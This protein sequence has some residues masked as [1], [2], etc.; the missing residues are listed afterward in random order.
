M[1][2]VDKLKN[3]LSLVE[4]RGNTLIFTCPVCGGSNLKLNDSVTSEKYGAY[5]C[6]DNSCSPRD[7][8]E[9]LGLRLENNIFQESTFGPSNIFTTSFTLEREPKSFDLSVSN[10]CQVKEN[11]Q[12]P[13][14]LNIKPVQRVCYYYSP[15]HRLVRLNGRKKILIL[16]YWSDSGWVAGVGQNTWPLYLTGC[17]LNSGDTLAMVEGEKTAEKVKATGLACATIC[18]AFF[19]TNN[20]YI[21]FLNLK[22]SSNIRNIVYIP[23][24]DVPG[25]K[26][27]QEVSRACEY[28]GFSY[29]QKDIK[30]LN[31]NKTPGFDLADVSNLDIIRNFIV[32]DI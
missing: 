6:W 20:I 24:D 11:Y 31:K 23:D 12:A 21:K 32:N 29:I 3:S 15:F 4:K 22:D 17:D 25:Y 26:K 2:L 7:I 8:K 1:P 18:S 14:A 28:A 30:K 5:K 16:Q 27:A 13:E 10:F 9:A 19:D